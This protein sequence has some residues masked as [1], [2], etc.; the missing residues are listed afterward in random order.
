MPARYW[1]VRRALRTLGI[2]ERQG[3]GSHVVLRDQRGRTYPV[4]LHNGEKSELTDVYIRG[5]C[6]AFGLD[7]E[8]FK[9]LL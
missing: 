5:I 6:R 4:T 1:A 7:Y 2:Q 3:K 9:K 8:E